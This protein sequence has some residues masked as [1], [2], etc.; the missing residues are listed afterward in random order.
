MIYLYLDDD[1]SD[2]SIRR[3]KLL[4]CIVLCFFFDFLW[5]AVVCFCHGDLQ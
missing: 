2:L 5:I 1:L 3:V 4:C